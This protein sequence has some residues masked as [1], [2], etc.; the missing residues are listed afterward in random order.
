MRLLLDTNAYSNFMRGHENVVQLV[1]SAD[2]L[3]MSPFVV[4]ELLFGFRNGSQFEKNRAQLDRFL[5]MS[6]VELLPVTLSTSD[7][8]SRIVMDLRQKGRPIPTNDIWI[9]AHAMESGA[10]LLS[11]DKHFQEVPG[12]VVRELSGS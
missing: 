1:R 11:R 3:L 4:G 12:L 5:A 7:R 10:E 8:Y 2:Q 6:V 9:A